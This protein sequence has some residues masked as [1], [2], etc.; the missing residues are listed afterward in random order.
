MSQ[1]LK[2]IFKAQ[3]YHLLI[4]NIAAAKAQA[5]KLVLHCLAEEVDS[6]T[7][8]RASNIIALMHDANE[9]LEEIEK[10]FKWEQD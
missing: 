4:S 5:Q 7:K 3:N 2:P 6:V 10:E 1:K 8:A 9:H